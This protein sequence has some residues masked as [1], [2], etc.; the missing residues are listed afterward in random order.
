MKAAV[1]HEFGPPEVLHYEDAPDPEPGPGQV[2]VKVHAVT[3]NRTLD[4]AVRAGTQ[5]Q[6]N[7]ILPGILGVDPSG[8]VVA[9]GPPAEGVHMPKVGD[10]VSVL[11]RPGP[12][13]D[14][15]LG[16]R[17]WG[18]DAELVK[19]HANCCVP[20]SDNLNY[21]EAS[22]VIRHCPTAFH[23]MFTMGELKKDQWVLVMGCSGGLGTIGVQIAKMVGAKVIGA[24][25]SAERAKVGLDLG[26]DFVVDYGTQDLTQAVMDITKG[27]GVD[28]VYDN[29]S[30]PDTWPK[31]FAS[32]AQGGKLV[33][34][35]AHGGPVVPLDCFKLYDSKITIMGSAGSTRQNVE[36]SLKAAAEGKIKVV[37]EKVFPLSQIV[38][39]H[40]LVEAGAVPGKVILDPTLG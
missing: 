40:K 2:I 20:I 19:A 3:V 34:A 21:H 37:I 32:I 12:G 14:G 16:V 29:I 4:C 5:M 18:G 15:M 26:A 17:R 13:E 24:A 30:N 25:G 31:A 38:E 10:R 28:L 8:E 9:L 23:L 7:P 36:D 39:A 11:S 35:G 27:H 22:V 33:T 1:F 6:R